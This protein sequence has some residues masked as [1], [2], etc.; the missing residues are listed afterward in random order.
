[1]RGDFKAL[2]RPLAA[3]L[4]GVFLAGTGLA[5]TVSVPRMSLRLV[6]GHTATA[7]QWTKTLSAIAEN[8][9]CCDEVWFSTGV[10]LPPLAWHREQAARIASAVEDVRR[11]GIAA[12]LQIQAT[13]GHDDAISVSEDCS[14]KTWTGWTGSTGVEARFCSCPRQPAFLDYFRVC[15]RIYA[16]LRFVR[17]WIDDDLRD[18]RHPPAT[19]GSRAGCWCATCLAAFG[20]Q[21]GTSWTRAG[22][23]AAVGTDPALAARWAAFSA[24]SLADV[25]RAIA[26]E[27]RE[28]SP[29]TRMGYQAVFW[30][31]FAGPVP[32]IVKA[33]AE[34]SGHPVGVRPGGGAYHDLNPFDQVVKSVR[35]SQF[36]RRLPG[37]LDVDVWCP[38]VDGYPRAYSSRSAQS[39]IVESFAALMFG[40]DSTSL[41]VLDTAFEDDALYSR[42][43]LRPLADAAPVLT[44]FARANEGAEPAGF[45]M[46]GADGSA[47]ARTALLGIPV[48]PG[49]GRRLGALTAAER[50]ADVFELGS[51]E[52]QRLRDGADARAGGDAPAGLESPFVGLMTPHVTAA[53]NLRTV[54]LLNVRIEPQGPVVLRLRGVPAGAA[55]TW[56][57]LRRPPVVLSETREGDVVRVTVP[58]V[59]AWNGGFVD[60]CDG[61]RAVR[62]GL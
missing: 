50:Q 42:T 36:R 32:A 30:D 33:L 29:E 34:A 1:M 20:A 44:A 37:A 27:F 26:A 41:Y 55:L 10:G 14:A 28:L 2:F 48:L 31:E 62:G 13:L 49:V 15:A 21:E 60:V 18:V 23:D 51:R 6:A 57:E 9:G 24:Q 25:A 16:P 17:V 43:A 53:G 35:A 3:L 46:D 22:L 54:A 4:G 61:R 5:D 59:G 11:I 12:S 52:I 39:A 19:D 45:A 47:V 56:R 40:F 8:P 58:A 38:E 7:T